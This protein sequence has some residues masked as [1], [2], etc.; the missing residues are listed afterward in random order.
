MVLNVDNVYITHWS[1]LKERKELL[2]K[3]LLDINITN[4]NW[5]ENYD[6]STWD[7]EE[8]KSEYPLIFGLNPKGR[9]LNHSEISLAL[10]HCWIIKDAL[11]K[12]CQSILILEDDVILD[13]SF[14]EK[15]NEYKL[16]LPT[17]WDIFFVGSCCNLHINNQIKGVNVYKTYTSRCCHAYSI[18]LSGLLKLKDEINNINEAIDWYFNYIIPELKLNTYW[19]EPSIAEQNSNFEST[20]QL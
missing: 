18:S 17:D 16:Q 9:N 5:V 10:K 7:I 4:Y 6:K 3:H 19:S 13:D 20:V 11:S 1:K 15:Y 2:T 8:I 12:G 14:I